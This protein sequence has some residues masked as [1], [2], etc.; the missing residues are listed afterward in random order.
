MMFVPA[1]C[2]FA[3]FKKREHGFAPFQQ[4]APYLFDEED[5]STLD[6]DSAVRTLE[7][8]KR[9]AAMGVW[10]L[11]SL[12]GKRLFGDL[13][14]LTF[15]LT[16]HFKELLDDDGDFESPYGPEANILIF[17]LSA[18]GSQLAELGKQRL[19]R[20]HS[21]I[22]RTLVQEGKFYITQTELDGRI[23]L[24]VTVMNPLTTSEDLQDLIKEVKQVAARIQQGN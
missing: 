1:L 2:A 5:H 24:R 23:W 16:R 12:F 4:K 10:G 9:A 8:T 21:N 7:C 22:R 20:L 18:Q 17:G 6:F 19:N 15:S 14:D 11:W 3:F 13:V